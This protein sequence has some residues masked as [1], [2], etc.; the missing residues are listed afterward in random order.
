MN[1]SIRRL[2]PLTFALS[3]L[4]ILAGC[5]GGGTGGSLIANPFSYGICG[6]L[7]VIL[8]IVAA[9][10]IVGSSR[11]TMSKVLWIAAIF[12][13]PLVGLILYYFFGR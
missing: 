9:I 12:F 10:E 3:A 13:L 7:H 2:A 4:V 1:L 6:F 5:H 8:W 11:D